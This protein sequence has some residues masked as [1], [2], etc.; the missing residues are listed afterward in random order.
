MALIV[1]SEYVSLTGRVWAFQYFLHLYVGN[2][3]IPRHFFGRAIAIFKVKIVAIGLAAEKHFTL[4]L[5][6]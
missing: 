4:F 5:I 2:A 6:E 1:G 3:C